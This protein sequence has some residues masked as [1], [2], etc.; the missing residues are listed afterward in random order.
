MEYWRY[1]PI[2]DLSTIQ[3]KTIDYLT[4]NPHTITTT[5]NPL[6]FEQYTRAVPEILTAIEGHAP[7]QIN[8][9]FMQDNR[10]GAAHKDQFSA[11]FRIN[12]PIA[13]CK[14]T[15]TCFYRLKDNIKGGVRKQLPNGEYYE[16]Y[17]EEHIELVSK[18]EINTATIIR[19]QAIHSITMVESR[20]PRIT[21][22]M[23]MH[24]TPRLNDA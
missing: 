11:P 16:H 9:Y 19:T 18:V 24:P 4:K 5:F 14:D 2:K 23:T 17:P 3:A 1:I 20:T 22:T 6:P 21:L 7:R 8:V 12:I 10:Q 13:N 15:W